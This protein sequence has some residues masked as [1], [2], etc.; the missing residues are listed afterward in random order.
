MSVQTW[1]TPEFSEAIESALEAMDMWSAYKVARAASRYGHH[2]SAHSIYQKISQ[3]VS[4]EHLYYW[5]TG[6]AQV[7]LGEMTLINR[8]SSGSGLATNTII[9]CFLF[10]YKSFLCLEGKSMTP[11]RGTTLLFRSSQQLPR[12]RLGP[13]K[14]PQTSSIASI[15]N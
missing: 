9:L 5:L 11:R 10:L 3:G 4:S 13:L 14:G 2:Q 1:W 12:F 15:T 7:S 8:T 6:L